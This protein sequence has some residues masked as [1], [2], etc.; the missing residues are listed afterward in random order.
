MVKFMILAGG[1]GSRLW[2]LSREE[3]PKQLLSFGDEK[4]LL[5]KTFVR[6]SSLCDKPEIITISNERQCNDV[7]LQLRKLDKSSVVLGEPIS[8][9]TAPAI[10][11]GLL[12]YQQT[13]NDDD[14]V[15]IVPS[16]HLI[17]NIEDFRE[18]VQQGMNIAEQGYIVTFGV[19]P[20]YPETGYGYIRIGK[21]MLPSGWKVDKFVEKPNLETAERYLE[22]GLYYWNSGIFMGKISTIINE[23]RKYIPDLYSIMSAHDFTKSTKIPFEIY[24]KIPSISI[25]YGVI[26]LS[27]KVALIELLSDWNDLGS[28]Q[29]VY[30]VSKKDQDGNVLIGDIVT[31]NVKK[32][33]IY[34]QKDLVAVSGLKNVVLIST[35]DAIMVCD[36]DNSQRVKTL[37]ERASSMV[38]EC[39]KFHRTVYRPWGYYTCLNRGTNYL[40]KLLCVYPNHELSVQ[41][42]HHRSEYWFVLEGSATVIKNEKRYDLVAG[43]TIDIPVKVIHSLKNLS[44]EELKILEVQR[45]DYISEDDIVRYKDIYERQ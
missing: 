11:S 2:P 1:S 15:L 31:D 13:S 16:D 3:Y 43:D 8:K 36:I 4:S 22:S 44:T 30:T 35:E 19:K 14:I 42:H 7:K 24:E 6:L 20:T 27:D 26:E 25:D 32:S 39:T 10:L 28:W 38:G 18:T 37:Y 21:P 23:I 41:L 45:G 12:Y 29:S 34:T 9:N 5:Q 17:R 40:T 33:L